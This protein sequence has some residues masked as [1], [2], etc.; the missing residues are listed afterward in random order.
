MEEVPQRWKQPEGE[1]RTGMKKRGK[2]AEVHLAKWIS[3]EHR[4]EVHERIFSE[5]A[6]S[7]LIM[8]TD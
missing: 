6:T 5:S 7:S 4:K 1:D 3:A 8:S 2:G